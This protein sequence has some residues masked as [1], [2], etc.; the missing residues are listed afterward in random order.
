MACANWPLGQSFLIIT[1][2]WRRVPVTSRAHCANLK[3]N[4]HS[5]F[6]ASQPDRIMQIKGNLSTS[7]GGVR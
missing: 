3:L 5:K 1:H 7:F 4:L 2:T 6:K